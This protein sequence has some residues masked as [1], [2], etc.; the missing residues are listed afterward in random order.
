[1]KITAGCIFTTFISYL[2]VSGIAVHL[3][4]KIKQPSIHTNEFTGPV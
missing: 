2:Y 4:Q 3:L 1:M